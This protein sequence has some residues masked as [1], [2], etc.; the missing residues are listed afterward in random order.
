MRPTGLFLRV[1]TCVA[2]LIW[3]VSAVAESDTAAPHSVRVV[4]V[5]ERLLALRLTTSGSPSTRPNPRSIVPAQDTPVYC[6]DSRY[7][8]CCLWADLDA[9][10][11]VDPSVCAAHDGKCV[12]ETTLPLTS[13]NK[14][15]CP[16]Q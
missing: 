16:L 15:N 3:A 9:A 14:N 7:P 8:C 11:C 5:T 4:S 2:I 12:T 1:T 13:Q 10:D 6:K